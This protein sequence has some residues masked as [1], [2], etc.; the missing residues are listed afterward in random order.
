MNKNGRVIIVDWYTRE[1][2]AANRDTLFAFGDNLARRGYGGQAAACR[3]QPNTVG[4]P[5]KI[6]PTEYLF[7]CDIDKSREPIIE[8]FVTLRRHLRAGGNIAW[9]KDGVGTGLAR[10][11]IT[12]PITLQAIEAA[13]QLVFSEAIS[14]THESF[15]GK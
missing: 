15:K 4:I 2:I 10:L 5:T 12:A 14:I 11:H 13:K 6:S 1:L 7:D 3:N 9:P 8:A